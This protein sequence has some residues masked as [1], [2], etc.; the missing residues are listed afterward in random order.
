[1]QPSNPTDSSTVTTNIAALYENATGAPQSWEMTTIDTSRKSG[2]RSVSAGLPP[3][4]AEDG[5]LVSSGGDS[6][7]SGLGRSPKTSIE[8]GDVIY[9]NVAHSDDSSDSDHK[10]ELPSE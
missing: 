1:M 9:A 5:V 10:D 4:V 8:S 6:L 3:T 7:E 2:N